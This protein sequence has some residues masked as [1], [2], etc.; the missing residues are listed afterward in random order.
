MPL[1]PYSAEAEGLL[2]PEEKE[3]PADGMEEGAIS[4]QPMSAYE[5]PVFKVSSR[6]LA[7]P[8]IP[9]RPA[10]VNVRASLMCKQIV[11]G[12]INGLLAEAAAMAERVDELQ[13]HP[14]AAPEHAS[15][16]EDD[17]APKA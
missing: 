11:P 15:E 13:K 17:K 16:E 4:A 1:P 14:E 5:S 12:S 2:E 10:D 3:E 9:V 6:S 8:R 7:L